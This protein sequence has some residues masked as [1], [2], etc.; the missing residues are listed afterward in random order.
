MHLFSLNNGLIFSINSNSFFFKNFS[1]SNFTNFSI[2]VFI[3]FIFLK[4]KFK[5]TVNKINIEI[6]I[7]L[8]LLFKILKNFFLRIIKIKFV[9]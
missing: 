5:L 4:L 9:K 6:I 3:D 1:S 7:K 8:P 2:L